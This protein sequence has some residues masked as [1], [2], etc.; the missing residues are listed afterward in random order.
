MSLAFL[1]CACFPGTHKL[2]NRV[3]G[4]RLPPHYGMLRALDASSSRFL[5]IG[6]HLGNDGNDKGSLWLSSEG[7][8]KGLS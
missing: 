2:S 7:Y 8:V 5:E 4:F 1:A 3:S 6:G